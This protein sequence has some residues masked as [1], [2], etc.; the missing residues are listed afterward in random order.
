MAINQAGVKI[1]P[2]ST[3]PAVRTFQVTERN[4]DNVLETREIQALVWVDSQGNT[5]DLPYDVAYQHE[6]ITEIRAVREL[7][8]RWLG[9]ATV[10]PAAASPFDR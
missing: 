1:P 10:T 8:E 9:P 7:L 2:P 4:A 3:G 5:I 6:L